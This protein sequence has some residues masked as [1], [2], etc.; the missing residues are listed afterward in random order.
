MSGQL[1]FKV[2]ELKL[3]LLQQW[4]YFGF[5]VY[6]PPESRIIYNAWAG[7]LGIPFGSHTLFNYT[8]KG[9]T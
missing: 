7:L 6:S 9:A 5:S 1:H 8:L 3:F 4:S 2:S